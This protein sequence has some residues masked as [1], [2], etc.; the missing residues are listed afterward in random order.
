MTNP[1]ESRA[2]VHKTIRIRKL[3]IYNC[4]QIWTEYFCNL[5][6][7]GRISWTQI[8]FHLN[9]SWRYYLPSFSLSFF[10]YLSECFFFFERSSSSSVSSFSFTGF[11][12]S[13]SWWRSS[14]GIWKTNFNWLGLQLTINSLDFLYVIVFYKV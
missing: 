6:T 3:R 11:G 9:V 5:L 10:S 4:S 13:T 7:N 12:R 8:N 2:Q 1:T 14:Q